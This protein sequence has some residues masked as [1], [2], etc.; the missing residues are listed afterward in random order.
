MPPF[1]TLL[2]FLIPTLG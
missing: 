2:P 1:Q